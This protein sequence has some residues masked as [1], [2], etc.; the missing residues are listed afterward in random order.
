[1]NATPKIVLDTNVVLDIFVFFNPALQAVASAL[2]QRQLQWIGTSHTMAELGHVLH[3]ARLGGRQI[4]AEHVLTLAFALIRLID[5]PEP[6]ALNRWRCTDASDQ[7]FID[8]ALST[9]ARWLLTRDRAVLKL[10]R[11]VAPSG[12]VI[13]VPERWA[14]AALPRPAP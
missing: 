9:G 3:H 11:K 4:D 8:L 2:E 5:V 14:P 1:M 6:L 10:A 7:K 13:Q 12:L